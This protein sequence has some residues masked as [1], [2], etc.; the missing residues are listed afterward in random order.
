MD[1]FTV[2]SKQRGELIDITS[3]VKNS[4]SRAG[5]CNG[6]GVVFLLHTTAGLT[7]NDHLDPAVAHDVLLALERAVPRDQPGFRHADGDSDAHAKASM[8]GSSVTLVVEDGQLALG[9]WQGIFLCEFDGPRTR[10]V[11]VSWMAAPHAGQVDTM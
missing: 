8:V 4:L 7:I 6:F 2:Q 11:K 5:V 10:S 3:L 1:T 9:R